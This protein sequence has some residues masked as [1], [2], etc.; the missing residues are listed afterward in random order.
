MRGYTVI[1]STTSKQEC[2]CLSWFIESTIS[3]TQPLHHTTNIAIGKHYYVNTF[4]TNQLEIYNNVLKY[5]MT[6]IVLLDTGLYFDS[7]I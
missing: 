4:T 6:N 3:Y 2:V 5:C 1:K 7:L